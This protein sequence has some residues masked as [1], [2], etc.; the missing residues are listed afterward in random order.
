MRTIYRS[1][2]IGGPFQLSHEVAHRD[3]DAAA[4]QIAPNSVERRQH[5]KVLVKQP[6]E[7]FA[8]RFRPLEGRRKRAGRGSVTTQPAAARLAD[9]NASSLMLFDDMELRLHHLIDHLQVGTAAIPASIRNQVMLF[10]LQML[11][12]GLA[13]RRT[14]LFLWSLGFIGT[15]RRL[16][17]V[18][19]PLLRIIIQRCGR[20]RR[21]YGVLFFFVRAVFSRCLR[22]A[23]AS[24]SVVRS[25]PCATSSARRATS[26]VSASLRALAS[27]SW[28]RSAAFS[29]R[30]ACKAS[31]SRPRPTERED[32]DR[33]R[34]SIPS[35]AFP[36]LRRRRYH[37]RRSAARSM[38]SSSAVSVAE[39]TTTCWVPSV[40]RGSSK[41]PRSSL[42]LSRSHPEPSN[43]TILQS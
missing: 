1:E 26:L 37:R 20:F 36:Q 25:L 10:C 18:L 39:S 21:R 40:A 15:L 17:P 35:M 9:R 28:A 27:V 24:S 11:G 29:S 41:V 34:L 8:R 2:K 19:E 32:H 7:P 31:C 33:S 12:D 13:P 43:Q 3:F 14:L 23:I 4:R 6:S 22:R 38:P 16:G 5:N 42:L 30:S